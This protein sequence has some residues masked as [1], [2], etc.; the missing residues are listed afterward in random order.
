MAS[1]ILYSS[2]LAIEA[3][4]YLHVQHRQYSAED[5]ICIHSVGGTLTTLVRASCTAATVSRAHLRR[6]WRLECG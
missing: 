4:I 1:T 2:R 5:L 6:P 3:L